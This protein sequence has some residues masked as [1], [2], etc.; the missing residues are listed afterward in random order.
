MVHHLEVNGST[1]LNGNLLTTENVG[2]GT[3]SP[4]HRHTIKTNFIDEN[5]GLM[6]DA[7][8]ESARLT[9]GVTNDSDDHIILHPNLGNVGIGYNN[10]FQKLT[11]SGKI[12]ASGNIFAG[13]AYN[14]GFYSGDTNC[15]FRIVDNG[16]NNGLTECR[17]YWHVSTRGFRILSTWNNS[18]PFSVNHEGSTIFHHDR[19]HKSNDGRE[20]VYYAI[21]STT[22]HRGYDGVPHIWRRGNDINII[23]L[24]DI[25]NVRASGAYTNISDGRI[26]KRIEDIDDNVGL[27]KNL[28]VQP[29]TYKYIDEEKG[30]HNVIRFSTQQIKEIIPEVVDLGE[31]KLP[32]GDQNWK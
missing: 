3:S 18:V 8:G 26:K 25:G 23:S 7:G 6:L 20:R 5:T 29:K 16:N 30:T 24:T 31:E 11:V 28:L 2:I 32:N 13:P 17:G 12:Q 27:E 15:G 19:W 22:F 21:N 1:R 4:E 14:G 9:I 10:P